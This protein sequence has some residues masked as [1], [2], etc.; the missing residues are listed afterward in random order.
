MGE[1]FYKCDGC[2]GRVSDEDIQ[3]GNAWFE[4]GRLRC[5]NCTGGLMSNAGADD[6]GSLGPSPIAP[7]IA[8]IAQ[9]S[10]RQKTERQI[11]GSGYVVHSLEAALWCFDNTASYRD[12]ILRAANLGEDA[13]T[14]AAVC[15][16]VAGAFYGEEGIPPE[17]RGKLAMRA[18]IEEL[19]D[20]LFEARPGPAPA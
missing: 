14:T 16:Q 13:D 19:A 4:K 7:A 1:S 15:G 5:N 10:W 17:W 12:A 9:R 18:K 8:S 3:V 2:G 11:R 6:A 20:A